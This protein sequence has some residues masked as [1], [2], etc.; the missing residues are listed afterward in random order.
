MYMKRRLKVGEASSK[1]VWQPGSRQVAL[2]AHALK[3]GSVAATSVE[4]NEPKL[5]PTLEPGA[6]VVTL[7]PDRGER[8][9][10]TIYA[11]PTLEPM[12]D[13]PAALEDEPVLDALID[14]PITLETLML[15]Y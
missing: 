12:I 11:E 9:L 3:R 14:E 5:L 13:E 6:R 7:F 15:E 10:N 8:Y 1:I 4:K 2:T